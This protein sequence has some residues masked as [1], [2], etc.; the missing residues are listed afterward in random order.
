MTTGGMHDNGEGSESYPRDLQEQLRLRPGLQMR[1]CCM[2]TSEHLVVGNIY[3]RN[4]LKAKF[5]I[6]D[7]TI[8]TGIFRPKCHDSIWLFMTEALAHQQ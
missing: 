8:N 5:E 1:K 4:E 2:L 3:S 7:S 6:K